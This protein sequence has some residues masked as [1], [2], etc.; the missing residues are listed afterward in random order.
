MSL[1]AQHWL[2]VGLGASGTSALRYLLREGAVCL[3]TDS[4]ASPPDLAALRT[5]FP[6][7]EFRIGG[8][9][10]PEPLNQFAGVVV[11][12][13]VALD[14]EFVQ[15]L[16]AAGV[17]ILGDVELFARALSRVPGP[18]FRVP[19][20][21][22][23]TGSNGKSTVTTLLGDMAR[24]AGLNVKVGGNLGKPVLDLLD[25]TAE[26]YV[27]ELSSFQLEAT[28]SLRSVAATVL[29]LSEDHLDRH[30][31]MEAYGRIK[32]RVYRGADVAV[33]NR[34]D[35]ATLRDAGLAA[36]VISFG[37]DAP[38]DGDYGLLLADGE[39]WLMRGTQRLLA[40]SEMRVMGLHNAANAL[41]ALALAEA[42]GIALAPALQALRAFP[43][44][45]HRCQWVSDAGGVTWIDDSKGTNVGSTLAALRGLSGPIVWLGGGRGKGQDFSPLRPPLAEKGRAAIVYGEDA[46]KLQRGLLGALPVSRVHTLDEAVREA[47]DCA[48]PGDQVLLSPACASLDQFSNYIER[49]LRFAQLARQG[50]E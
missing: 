2:V 11:S 5:D 20:V 32:A 8:F 14:G 26:L 44:L 29:N 42:A 47:R 49:G 46:D 24:A 9:S 34:D 50:A 23:I 27:L 22:A 35:A 13:G 4:R 38:D 1:R 30:H 33:V 48:Q 43:G 10:A 45:P 25:A 3:A 31:T 12:P 37:S 41:A 18:R 7:V 17:P 36:R 28:H 15:R 16:A 19:A 21:I 40:M 39:T 6:Q